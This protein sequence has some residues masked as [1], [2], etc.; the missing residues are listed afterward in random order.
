MA[1]SFTFTGFAHSQIVTAGEYKCWTPKEIIDDPEIDSQEAAELVAGYCKYQGRGINGQ[2]GV[3]RLDAI[4]QQIIK[5]GAPNVVSY[6]E[7][8]ANSSDYTIMWWIEGD[9][10]NEIHPA[11][12]VIGKQLQLADVRTPFT[13]IPSVEIRA[14]VFSLDQNK[15]REIGLNIAANFARMPD[16][17]PGPFDQSAINVG[18]GTGL[19][20]IVGGVSDSMASA[21]QIGFSLSSEKSYAREQLSI[22]TLCPV[23]SYCQFE[24]STLNYFETYTGNKEGK[25]GIR[26]SMVPVLGLGDDE[27]KLENM[28]F[29]LGLKTD[30][31]DAPVNS[32]RPVN[33]QTHILK[34]G[35]LHVLGSE[36]REFDSKGTQLL[37][38]DKKSV[39]SRVILLISASLKDGKDAEENTG[40]L[41]ASPIDRSFT[42]AELAQLDG[43]I[44]FYETLSSFEKVC[45][46]DVMNPLVAE[47]ICG[48]H[49]TKMNPAFIDYWVDIR[50]DS[51]RHL[52]YPENH[53]R[54]VKLGDIYQGKG[55]Y[56]IPMLNAGKGRNAMRL[57]IELSKG[58]SGTDLRKTLKSEKV[59]VGLR[60]AFAYTSGHS[61]PVDVRASSIQPI[62]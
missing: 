5:R 11:N 14:M 1:V 13:R 10:P 38:K 34:D 32:I 43:R 27:I 42:K 36:I 49:L 46:D 33:G 6:M 8:R 28:Q 60:F 48:F 40:A 4:P 12:H 61:D 53:I 30:D 20:N 18:A 21:I 56:Q 31:P 15:E 59:P 62:K 24:D 17:G 35:E 25:L 50:I 7:P 26:Y 23:G 19:L 39:H 47:K 29:T 22:T 58:G 37:G 16:D 2:G 9:N 41:N 57:R 44:G 3:S 45:F 55:Y 51:K 54:S 52:R